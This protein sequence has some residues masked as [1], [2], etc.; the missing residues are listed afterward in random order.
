MI[1][2]VLEYSRTNVSYV[3]YVNNIDCEDI[4]CQYDVIQHIV[5]VV[6]GCAMEKSA[7]NVE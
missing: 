4:K 1:A 2:D 5:N 6:R 7:I 3:F